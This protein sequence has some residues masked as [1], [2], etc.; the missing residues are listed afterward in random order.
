M[1]GLNLVTEQEK[2]PV[3]RRLQ[4]TEEVAKGIM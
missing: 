1:M 3:N 4:G 2:I